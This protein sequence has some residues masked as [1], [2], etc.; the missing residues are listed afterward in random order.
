MQNAARLAAT[1]SAA[2]AGT[3]PVDPINPNDPNQQLLLQQQQM[4]LQQ[5]QQQQA[6]INSATP[7]GHRHPWEHIDEIH[8][9]LKTA[10]PLLALSMEMIVDQ[11]STRFKPLP[12]EDIY[13]LISALLADGIQVSVHFLSI[14][15]GN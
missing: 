13:R 14:G 15:R 2:S 6:G 10:F 3:L 11:V 9:I 5:Q 12:D 8:A 4:I 7:L 1:R